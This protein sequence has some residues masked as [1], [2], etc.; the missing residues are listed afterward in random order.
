MEFDRHP[1]SND[2]NW[3]NLMPETIKRDKSTDGSDAAKKLA[4][5]GNGKHTSRVPPMRKFRHIEYFASVVPGKNVP[6]PLQFAKNIIALEK[7]F[8]IPI[9][10]IVHQGACP[11]C[12]NPECPKAVDL[13]P[14]M[15]KAFQRELPQIPQ[16]QPIGILL[17]S[18]GGDA[19]TAYRIGRLLQRRSG[20]NLTI[21]IP[22]YAKSAATLLALAGSRLIMSENAELG[23]LDVQL[24]DPQ[25][26]EFCSGLDAVQ[27]LER[28]H[29]VA[30]AAI[31]QTMARVFPKSG[32]RIDV[33]LP[34]VMNY[35]ANFYRPLLEKID[36]I[37]YTRKSRDLKVAEE[38]A[39]R[40]MGEKVGLKLARQI[41][42]ELVAKYPTHGFVIDRDEASRSRQDEVR[43]RTMSGLGM[44]IAKLK[45]S[46]NKRFEAIVADLIP[47]LDRLA[48]VMGRVTK[49]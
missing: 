18:P 19:D 4:G 25:R 21:I 31:D 8:Q 17:E 1:V 11:D 24:F 28:L 20:N 33:M 9:W 10:L 47:Y 44:N 48:I 23:P 2:L 39:V 30:L 3:G 32:K 46:V 27:S 45:P 7:L 14:F 29:S 38:Y 15:F 22:Q 35:V 37:D 12:G 5:N 40:L 13:E 41:A 49:L 6:L 16:G 36:T 43:S 26:E 42:S 34:L